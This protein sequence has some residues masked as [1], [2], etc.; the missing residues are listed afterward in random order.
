MN[1]Q[2]HPKAEILLVFR[3]HLCPE[4]ASG[5]RRASGFGVVG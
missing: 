5:V 3:L 1:G 2:R 4:E